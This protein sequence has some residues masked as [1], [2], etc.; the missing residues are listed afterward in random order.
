MP[1]VTSLRQETT[2]L[3][4]CASLLCYISVV[5]LFRNG[6]INFLMLT[7]ATNTALFFLEIRLYLMMSNWNRFLVQMIGL[8][9][10]SSMS[11]RCWFW[12]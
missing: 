6:I 11:C 4:V 8:P 2:S 10:L 3:L 1:L 12:K 5:A 7:A 9:S